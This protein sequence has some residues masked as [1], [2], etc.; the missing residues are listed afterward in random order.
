MQYLFAQ[1]NTYSLYNV[2]LYCKIYNT[3]I[4]FIP[5]LIIILLRVS[6]KYIIS[7]Y[8]PEHLFIECPINPLD[9]T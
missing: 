6:P 1:D 4:H 2:Y 8:T 7:S 5:H 9:C 3:C